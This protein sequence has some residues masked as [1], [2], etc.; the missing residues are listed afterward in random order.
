VIPSL[1]GWHAEYGPEGLVVIGNHYP[2]FDYEADLENLKQAIERLEIDYPVAQDND[3]LTW[4]AY[5]NRYWPALFLID[6]RGVI[7]YHHIGEG[8]YEETEAAIQAL[9]AEPYP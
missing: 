9:L 3:G 4:R 5:R 6:K 1:R 7:R 2:E 8:R